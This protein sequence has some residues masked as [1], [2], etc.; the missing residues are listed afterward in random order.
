MQLEIKRRILHDVWKLGEKTITALDA[1][2]RLHGPTRGKTSVILTVA[3]TIAAIAIGAEALVAASAAG[4]TGEAIYADDV[5]HST[6]PPHA[7]RR[8]INQPTPDRR[9]A[10]RRPV[11]SRLR[12]RLN[13]RQLRRERDGAR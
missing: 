7:G 11:R 12:A 4:A 8:Q 5:P 10:G 3:G 6:R 13:L 9:R 2:D 1:L